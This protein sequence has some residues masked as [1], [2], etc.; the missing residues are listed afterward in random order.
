MAR[1][2]LSPVGL[3]SGNTLPTAGSA[4]DLF[5]KADEGKVYVHTGSGW[6]V[7][8]GPIG[9]TGPTGPQ[10]SVGPTGSLGPTGP[11]GASG[12]DGDIGP[13]GPTGATGDTGPTGQ[14]VPAGGFAGQIL[15]KIDGTDYNTEWVTNSGG[16]GS[17]DLDSLTDVTIAT[18]DIGDILYYNSSTSTW[19]NKSLISLLGAFGLLTGDGGEYNTSNFTGTIDAGIY[20]TTDFTGIYDGGNESSF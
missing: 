14:G 1:K 5:F 9:P 11:T 20:N 8:Q 17:S 2:F 19:E 13:T 10:G 12:T 4:G 3:P 16:A 6:V 15:A 7:Q 18:P